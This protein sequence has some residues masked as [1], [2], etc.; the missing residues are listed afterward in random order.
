MIDH[1]QLGQGGGERLF[2]AGQHKSSLEIEVDG[3]I[4]AEDPESRGRTAGDGKGQKAET[5]T[6][7]L[8]GGKDIEIFNHVVKNRDNADRL[9][10]LQHPKGLSYCKLI[11]KICLLSLDRVGGNKI[12]GTEGCVRC[13]PCFSVYNGSG[14]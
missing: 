13:A 14:C 2:D 4:V 6:L 12:G 10:I 1:F 3:G 8:S 9:R 11:A 7:T 5:V